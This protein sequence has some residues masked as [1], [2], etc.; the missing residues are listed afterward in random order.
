MPWH[1]R[2]SFGA[3][4]P[5]P[6]WHCSIHNHPDDPRLSDQQWGQVATALAE[7]TGPAPAGIG[8]RCGG[9]PF[10]TVTTTFIW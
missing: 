1:E 3:S 7:G 6:V 9:R 2:R 8:D 10:A 4:P 5:R